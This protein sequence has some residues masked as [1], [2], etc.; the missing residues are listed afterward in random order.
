MKNL[1][2]IHEV[3]QPDTKSH[4]LYDFIYIK[5]PEQTNI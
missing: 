1:K 3:K 2:H 5:R 4:I